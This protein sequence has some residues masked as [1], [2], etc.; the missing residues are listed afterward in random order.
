[1]RFHSPEPIKIARA[2]DSHQGLDCVGWNRLSRPRLW[3]DRLAA[4]VLGVMLCRVANCQELHSA[5]PSEIVSPPQ[6]LAVQQIDSLLEAGQFRDAAAQLQNL[7]DLPPALIESSPLQAAATQYVQPYQPLSAWYHQRLKKTLA[8]DQ[9]LQSEYEKQWSSL[10][11]AASR[12]AQQSK[13]PQEAR[14][15]VDRFGA[16]NQSLQLTKLLID[17]HFEHGDFLCGVQVLDAKFSSVSR[18]S[19]QELDPSAPD[20]SVP[21]YRAWQRFS[22]DPQMSD[23]LL[24]RWG[25]VSDGNPELVSGVLDRLLVAAASAPQWLDYDAISQWCKVAATKLPKVDADSLSARLAETKSWLN[26]SAQSSGQS[27]SLFF[28][29]QRPLWQLQLDRWLNGSDLTPAMRPAVGQIQAAQPYFPQIYEGKVFLHEL[30]KIRAFQ[31]EDGKSWPSPSGSASLFDSQTGASAFMPLG[32]PLQGSPRAS[33]SILDGC[34]YARMGSP[35]TAWNNRTVSNDGSSISYVIGLDLDREGSSLRGFPLR[36]RPPQFEDAEF[37]GTPVAV[38]QTLVVVVAERDNVGIR[39]SLAA[40]DRF[41]GRLLWRT[42]PLGAGVV[43]GSEGANLISASQPVVVGGLIYYSTDLGSVA[44]V[45]LRSGQTLWLSRYQRAHRLQPDFPKPNRY[46][47]RDG[48][49]CR[50]HQGIVYCVPQDC[51][52]LIA[53]DALTGDLVWSTSDEDVSDCTYELAVHGDSL[54]V[55]GD[56]LVWLHR[57][58]GR[59]LGQFPNRTTPGTVHALPQPRGLGRAFVVADRIYWPSAQQV[60]VFPADAAAYASKAGHPPDSPPGLQQ[61]DT[62]FCGTEGGNIYAE[63]KWFLMATPGRLICFF[64]D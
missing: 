54:V 7:R 9:Q 50:L 43:L 23:L 62:I 25:V 59:I 30:T 6:R 3:P 61:I 44:C 58:T 63:G 22:H 35:V 52:E 64:Q 37:E 13:D 47:Y 26:E 38:G 45:D 29:D 33:L 12:A 24:Q 15:A 1:M 55:G 60:S 41:S 21:W 8:S 28:L 34:L 49:A 18:V 48:V 14:E 2:N 53:L 42:Q 4:I 27:G 20:V 56:R 17:I 10:V 36:L 16:I 46:R 31:L 51:P 32:Y 11:L 40:F 19:L 39:R 57:L 5:D